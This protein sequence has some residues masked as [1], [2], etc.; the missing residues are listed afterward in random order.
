MYVCV[1]VVQP[2][3]PK[4]LFVV[5]ELPSECAA[6]FLFKDRAH[7]QV[8]FSLGNPDVYDEVVSTQR[9]YIRLWISSYNSPLGTQKYRIARK[10]RRVKFSWKLIRLSFRDFIFTDSDPIA[11]INDV[12]IVLRIK[13]FADGDKS[14]KT[15]KI[16]TRETF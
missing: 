8:L 16:L 10:F 13:I 12:N 14:T 2:L 11:I 9:L 15:M 3:R 4:T 1:C 6:K 5:S 7:T